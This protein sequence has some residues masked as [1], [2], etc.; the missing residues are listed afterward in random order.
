MSLQTRAVNILTKAPEEWG[1]IAA[2]SATVE[3]LIRGYAAPLAAIPAV[4]QFI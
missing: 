4:C 1:T 3:G 2:E